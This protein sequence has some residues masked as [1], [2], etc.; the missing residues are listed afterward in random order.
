M[1]TPLLTKK[2]AALLVCLCGAL[3]ISSAIADELS[4]AVTALQTAMGKESSP[5]KT[6]D[7]ERSRA[8]YGNPGV[9]L[10]P[11]LRS[12]I[13]QEDF[14]RAGETLSQ[15]PSYFTSE[16]VL[17][18]AEKLRTALDARMRVKEK[19]LTEKVNATTAGVAKAVRDAKNPAD[20]DQTLSDLAIA[21]NDTAARVSR[22]G[23][24]RN[25]R[26]LE[27]LIRFV[28]RWQDYLASREGVDK[29][30]TLQILQDILNIA[31]PE[32]IPRS[33]IIAAIDK[34]NGAKQTS[35]PIED[36]MPQIREVL[37]K[38][39]TPD[40]IPQ[41]L[42]ALT[43]LLRKGD[44][45][46]NG[47]NDPI[48]SAKS[49]LTSLYQVFCDYRAGL[50]CQWESRSQNSQNQSAN[51]IH[52]KILP[53][54]VE[55]L[56]LISTR[57]LGVDETMK[58]G[59]GES[60]DDYIDRMMTAAKQKMDARLIGRLLEF[61]DT[62]AGKSNSSVYAVFVRTLLAAQNQETA[63]QFIPAVISYESVLKT[64]GE[65]VPAEEIG[66]RLEEIKKAH[67]EDYEKGMQLSLTEPQRTPAGYGIFSGTGGMIMPA[68][69]PA[70]TGEAGSKAAA[71]AN[72]SSA[73]T[74]PSPAA[75]ARP[76]TKSSHSPKAAASPAP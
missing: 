66:K 25:Q 58:P 6:A 34:I 73:G 4:D 63:G 44:Y 19:E 27:G 9:S 28:T 76:S 62:L 50:P 26:K 22:Y 20:L 75:S 39:K 21:Q 69:T 54:R 38:T 37:E 41:A 42:E 11:A 13:S 23:Q 55:L 45:S 60:M 56:R 5:G 32:I 40:A 52:I 12:A 49:E 14:Q 36:P 33:E 17:K 47:W 24:D 15:I 7:G 59:A 65:F 16:E 18:A 51:E 57:L 48:N 43:A 67:P 31:P 1:N 30:K 74:S 70:S 72:A 35:Q 8:L 29:Q 68:R 46:I 10:M 71:S 2:I 3:C 61:K 64:G 53:L